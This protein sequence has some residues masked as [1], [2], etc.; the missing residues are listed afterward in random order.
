MKFFNT[1]GPIRPEKHYFLPH[2]LNWEEVFLLIEQE[3]YFVLHAPR[4]SGKTTA[5][6]E[7]VQYLNMQRRYHAVY[8]NIEA[9][10]AARDDV[11]TALLSILVSLRHAITVWLDDESPTLTFLNE[12]ISE[13]IPLTINSL[14]EALA[15]FARHSARPL[16]L[17]V[18]E[19]DALIGD[20]LL[21]VLRQLRA[22]YI[23]RPKG[24]PQSICLVGLRDVR[25]YRVWSK[26][27]G[28]YVS[29]ASPFNIKARSLIL[30]NFSP[31]EVEALLLQHTSATGQAFESDA[32]AFVYEQTLGQP[33]LVNALAYEAAFTLVTDRTK[34][35]TKN[36]LMVAKE[37]IIKR[38]D[39]HLDSLLDKLQE[40]RV[41]PIIDAII[42]SQTDISEI[43]YFQSDAVQYVRD[44]GLIKQDRME[45]ANPIYR[46]IIPRVLSELTAQSIPENYA[47]R[48]GYVRHD[49]SL[50][51]QT[52]LEAFCDFYRDNAAIWN[53]KFSYK[54]AGPHLLL[55]AFLQR[56]LNGGG[57]VSREY[58]LGRGRVDLL[59][60]W[61][62][63]RIVLELKVLRR[64]TTLREGVKQTAQ[65]MIASDAKEGHLLLFCTDPQKPW[66]QRF[67][68]CRETLE[69]QTVDIWQM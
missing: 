69:G 51:M 48:V 12:C 50:D 9:A 62:C 25:D 13:K 43:S 2:R 5:I 66:P 15:F 38:R 20:S 3:K 67:L 41:L 68:R 21:S 49:G 4:Q 56:I 39:T 54:E 14:F 42:N 7:L 32:V 34:A 47:A 30:T 46:E 61:R 58:A 55:M 33:W 45:I 40:E 37:T 22:G 65:Y 11:K 24:F 31:K 52:L 18:D 44:L 27:A 8:I 23:E 64:T 17:F 63:Q 26:E 6:T 10:Q 36:D 59:I 28:V 60:E 1:E 16:V 29:T 57:T 19:I 35:I 53:E